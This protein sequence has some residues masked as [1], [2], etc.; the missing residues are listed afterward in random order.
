MSQI[1]LEKALAT[2]QKTKVAA[3]EY[4]GLSLQSPRWTVPSES[5]DYPLQAAI[6]EFSKL[7]VSHMIN[8]H[9]SDAQDP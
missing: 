3:S 7:V 5:G 1:D 4:G 9:Q 2:S 6:N 8:L